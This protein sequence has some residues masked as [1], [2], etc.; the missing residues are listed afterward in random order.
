VI[1][2]LLEKRQDNAVKSPTPDARFSALPAAETLA[3]NLAA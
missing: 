1:A 3:F 2:E